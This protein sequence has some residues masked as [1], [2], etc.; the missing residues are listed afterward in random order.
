MFGST[1]LLSDGEAVA[2]AG[3]PKPESLF[4]DDFILLDSRYQTEGF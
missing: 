2:P 1:S 3:A 4:Y